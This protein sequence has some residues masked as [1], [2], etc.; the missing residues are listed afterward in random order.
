MNREEQE[1]L[2]NILSCVK[3]NLNAMEFYGKYLIVSPTS[4]NF[5]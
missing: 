3:N 2:G 4:P 1:S 5:N